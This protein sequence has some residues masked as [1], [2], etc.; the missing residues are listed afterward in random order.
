MKNGKKVNKK[1]LK[2]FKK[3]NKDIKIIIVEKVK[4]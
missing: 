4:N 1:N 2:D 3:F